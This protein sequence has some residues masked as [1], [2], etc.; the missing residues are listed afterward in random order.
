M[1]ALSG[2]ALGIARL[3]CLVFG[4]LLLAFGVFQCNA[5]RPPSVAMEPAAGSRVDASP[6]AVML[7]FPDAVSSDSHGEVASAFTVEAH[8]EPVYQTGP[9][10]VADGPDPADRSRRTLR[11]AL[12]PGLPAGVYRV[13]WRTSRGPGETFQNGEAHF[14]IGTDV[15]EHLLQKDAGRGGGLTGMSRRNRATIAGG[16][17]FLLLVPLLGLRARP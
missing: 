12:E 14:G 1:A 6:S 17:V 4:V 8:G 7:R 10:F 9:R 16:I 13:S 11:V 3:L 2:T 5:S 15:P